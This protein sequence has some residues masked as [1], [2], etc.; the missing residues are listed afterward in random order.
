[1]KDQY[2]L[3][4]I[5]SILRGDNVI[6]LVHSVQSTSVPQN[7]CQFRVAFINAKA[8]KCRWIIGEDFHISL[9]V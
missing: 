2:S 3:I 7:P 8:L 5:P 9:G 1:M 4:G 6:V